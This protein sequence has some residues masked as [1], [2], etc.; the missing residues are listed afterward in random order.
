MKLKKRGRWGTPDDI[1]SFVIYCTCV[2]AHFTN[3]EGPSSGGSATPDDLCRSCPVEKTYSS[4][5]PRTPVGFPPARRTCTRHEGG[6]GRSAS[7]AR[8]GVVGAWPSSPGPL[9]LLPRGCPASPTP[10]RYVTVFLN[11][12]DIQMLTIFTTFVRFTTDDRERIL[13]F[14]NHFIEYCSCDLILWLCSNF[15][16]T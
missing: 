3:T 12:H 6:R 5:E 16:P 13:A 1:N 2:T 7:L 15:F 9:G 8:R 14:L 10:Q 11:W 4:A